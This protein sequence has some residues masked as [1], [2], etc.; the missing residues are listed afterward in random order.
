MKFTTRDIWKWFRV[1]TMLILIVFVFSVIYLFA[2]E[3][4]SR[5]SNSLLPATVVLQQSQ[6][7][8]FENQTQSMGSGDDW[9]IALEIFLILVFV[10]LGFYFARV[11]DSQGNI[12]LSLTVGTRLILVYGVALIFFIFLASL[13]VQ[14][15]RSINDQ[16]QRIVNLEVKTTDAVTEFHHL[17]LEKEVLVERALRI[18]AK[19]SGI[20]KE[21]L[22][23]IARKYNFYRQQTEQMLQKAINSFLPLVRISGQQI[24]DYQKLIDNFNELMRKN[25]E[26][27]DQ[28]RLIINMV[29]SGQVTKA[30]NLQSQLQPRKD[31]LILE[32]NQLKA[33]MNQWRNMSF[34]NMINDIQT[35]QR[36]VIIFRIFLSIFIL[37]N[38]ILV[39]RSIASHLNKHLGAEPAEIGKIIERIADG[40]LRH[41][42]SSEQKLG[43]LANIKRMV[44]RMRQS[45]ADIQI[46]AENVVAGSEQ[47]SSTAQQL[48]QGSTEQ[49]ASTEQISASMEQM[50]SNIRQNA[51]NA[52]RAEKIAVNAARDANEG[53]EAVKEAVSA[54][55]NIAEG[56]SI[57]EE[58]AR[59]TNMLAL[60]AAIEAARAGEQGKGFAVVA[61]EVRKLAERSRK[62]ASE[63]GEL[64]M[65]SVTTVERAGEILYRLVPEI[66]KT[67]ELVQEI[68]AAS[69]EQRLGADQINIAIQQ[70]DSVTQ[71]NAS[72]AEEL[73]ATAEELSGQAMQ[74]RAT[75]DFFQVNENGKS[76]EISNV[77]SFVS[78]SGYVSKMKTNSEEEDLITNGN[79]PDSISLDL[80][81][82][83]IGNDSLDKEFEKY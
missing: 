67:S 54:M 27:D 9:F 68:S 25:R 50:V 2:G 6:P 24:G 3:K 79:Q 18:S 65:N 40:D 33:E 44:S 83:G 19:R 36:M 66:R 81:G 64:T 70:L 55:H 14:K 77:S 34:T 61:A 46:A 4:N 71:Q 20:A 60:N 43:L 8:V 22:N 29:L 63:I 49:A 32:T 42:I 30:M 78:N 7:V 39:T 72:S 74:L 69:K 41:E 73:S 56:I 16:I 35:T 57:I 10:A 37:L 80:G 52:E 38:S 28:D 59:Q 62:A 75:I 58:I 26:M 12:R 11:K 82:N 23:D 1:M 21:S 76:K 17:Q 48:S 45:V 5:F 53:G 15:L 47:L 31:T 51:D 13:G